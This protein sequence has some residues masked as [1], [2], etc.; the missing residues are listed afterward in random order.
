[1]LFRK[2]NATDRTGRFDRVH[3]NQPDGTVQELTGTKF[4]DLPFDER[5]R[6]LLSGKP[7]FW[8]KDK[9]VAMRDAIKWK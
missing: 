6:V 2:S 4:D 9:E 3:V 1:M 5:I 7:R 8:L